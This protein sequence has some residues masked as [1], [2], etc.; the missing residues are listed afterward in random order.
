MISAITSDGRFLAFAPVLRP[1]V[2]LKSGKTRGSSLDRMMVEGGEEKPAESG[3]TRL[4][5]YDVEQVD[6]ALLR[7]GLSEINVLHGAERSSL[8]FVPAAFATLVSPGGRREVLALIEETQA[9]LG[10]RIVLE[11]THLDPGLPPS[12]LVQVLTQLR[13]T[14]RT[15]FARIKPRRR[16]ILA[17]ADCTLAGVVIEAAHIENPEDEAG[18]IRLRLAMQAV[19]PRLMLQN[20]RSTA[21]INAAHAA[22]ISYASVDLL[23]PAGAAATRMAS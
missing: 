15:V 14:C 3:M 22:G 8:L 18:L 23:H 21:A 16:A 4:S 13:P 5:A 2:A 19:G 7:R 11:V 12:R 1:V 10:A 20:L 9:R 17:L 6:R